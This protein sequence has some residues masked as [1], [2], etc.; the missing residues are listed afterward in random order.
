MNIKD[1]IRQSEFKMTLKK[2]IID[3]ENFTDIGNI[4]EKEIVI[5]NEDQTIKILGNK[6]VIKKLLNYEILIYG[7]YYNILIKDIDE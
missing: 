1:Y 2:N 7:N 6:L 5:Y 4:S 3:V